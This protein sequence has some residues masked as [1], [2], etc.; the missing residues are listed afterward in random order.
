MKH[1][2]S[3]LEMLVVLAI[4]ALVI[5]VAAPAVRASVERLTLRGDARALMTSLRRL[6]EDALDSQTDIT[7]RPVPGQ[8]NEIDVSNG[9]TI[10]LTDGTQVRMRTAQ[11]VLV[12][13]DGTIS[14]AIVLERGGARV[15]VSAAPLTGRPQSGE[16]P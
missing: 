8:A 4:V 13:W 10:T 15:V 16:E 14:G 7:L 11:G 12:G 1:G 3:L 5:V 2:C 9:T 6:R